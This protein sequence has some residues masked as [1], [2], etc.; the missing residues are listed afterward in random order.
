MSL[1]SASS[2][3]G[4]EGNPP[5]LML[6]SG[7]QYALWKERMS[8]LCW[9]STRLD[10]FALTDLECD[11]LS[12]AY[13][14]LKD[15]DILTAQRNDVIGKCWIV[16]TSNLSDELFLKVAHVQKGHIASLI[17]EIRSSLAV[18]SAE[19]LQPLR[20]ELYSANMR[21]CNNDLQSYISYIITRKDKLAFL[22]SEI[23]EVELVHIFLKGLSSVFNPLQVHF[24]IPNMLPADFKSAVA[25]VR[26][27]SASPAVAAELA[28]A[29][30]TVLLANAFTP[31][32]PSNTTRD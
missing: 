7:E 9:A 32:A 8:N 4:E 30:A 25:I 19:D 6:K 23:P 28:K 3:S 15:K 14:D 22:K 1:N 21:D 2:A 17:A 13:D 10:A 16:L 11:K 20:V 12:K 18:G 31:P 26:K 5:K 29:K 27:Y 24:A